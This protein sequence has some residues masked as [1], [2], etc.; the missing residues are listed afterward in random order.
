MC[1]PENLDEIA[2]NKKYAVAA[3]CNECEKSFS[4]NSNLTQH[5]KIFHPGKLKPS[6]NKSFD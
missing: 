1:I 3:F 6:Y 5:V 2:P 4:K